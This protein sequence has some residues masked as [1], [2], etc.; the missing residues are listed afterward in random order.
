ML[1]KNIQFQVFLFNFHKCI[2]FCIDIE[3]SSKLLQITNKYCEVNEN[4]LRTN[5]SSVHKFISV[6]GFVCSLFTIVEIHKCHSV[7]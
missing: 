6:I 3:V 7:K 4:Y 2:V 1:C 5:Y